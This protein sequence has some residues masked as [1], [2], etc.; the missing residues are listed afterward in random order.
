MIGR[1]AR[2]LRRYFADHWLVL[3]TGLAAALPVIVSTA[4]GLSADWAPE[5]DQAITATRAHD[6][7]T[8][9]TPL[10]GA[11]S[12]TSNLVGDPT[13]SPGPLLYWLLAVPVRLPGL[14][15]LPLTMAM[16]S[17]AS[18]LGVVALAFRRGGRP[19]MFVTAAAVAIMC[20]SLQTEVPREIWPPSAAV[21]TFTLL[22][23]LCWS[24]A[25]GEYRLLPLVALTA[26]FAMQCHLAYVV[27]SLAVVAVGLVGLTASR[28]DRSS[29]RRWTLAGLVV[30][31]L[32]WSAPLV[33]QGLS[34]AGSDRGYGNL[35]RLVDATQSRDQ[36]VGKKGG[37]YAVVRAI[38]VAPW[39]L[40][41]PQP[42]AI[43]AFELFRRPA[44][45]TLVSALVVLGALGALFVIAARRRRWDVAAACALALV[46]CG[47]LGAV[48]AAFPNTG[49]TVFSYGYASWWASPAGMFV[50]LAVGWS[51]VILL[52]P[53]RA[54][55]SIRVPAPAAALGLA[56][57]L[58]AAV[59]VSASQGP[60]TQQHL[61]KPAGTVIDRVE[62]ALPDPGRVRVAGSSLEFEAPAVFALRRR[63]ATVGVDF[64]EQV[65]TE[66]VPVG[67]TYDQVVDIR[68]GEALPPGARLVTRLE[69]TKAPRRTFTVSLRPVRHGR[70]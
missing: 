68:E 10:V 67:R 11:W 33:D 35:A 22:I 63:G 45:G 7:L 21:M 41:A 50:W 6:V 12:T 42:L 20:A 53:R 24:V 69:I 23:F 65:G 25:C 8:S 57:V 48:T 55:D 14:A 58:C 18:V 2:A 70:D 36:P 17:L 27:P 61:Y 39:W 26:S 32:C 34:W 46:L 19:L 66:Y 1:V 13:F 5:A 43:R 49:G 38:G 3:M 40:R 28:G 56:G 64:G 47:A 44:I 60:D 62:D 16:V 4:R 54:L 51:A 15:A 29:L 30:A 52:V 9:Q 59:V 37:A 31:A